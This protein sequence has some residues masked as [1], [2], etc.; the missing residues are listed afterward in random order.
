MRKSQYTPVLT[1]G[2]YCS[3]VALLLLS[4]CVGATY[5]HTDV[6]T[7]TTPSQ[8]Y[9]LLQGV[10][11][12]TGISEM[13]RLDT[14][15]MIQLPHIRENNVFSPPRPP[16]AHTNAGQQS[17]WEF[18]TVCFLIIGVCYLIISLD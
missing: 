5:K 11:P 4:G 7:W 8:P 6:P 15:E 13:Q 16:N 17:D 3:V 18:Y 2:Y 12:Q 9:V 10:N 1:A 14:A